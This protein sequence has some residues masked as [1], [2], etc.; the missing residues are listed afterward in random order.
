[1]ISIYNNVLSHMKIKLKVYS[2]LKL[3]EIAE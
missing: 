3:T 1:M 2:I